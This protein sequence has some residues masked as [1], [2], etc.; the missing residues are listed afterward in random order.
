MRNLAI[1]FLFG[2][3][4]FAP[5]FAFAEDGPPPPASPVYPLN[6]ASS[7]SLPFELAWE[8]EPTANAYRYELIGYSDWFNQKTKEEQDAW[9]KEWANAGI[10]VQMEDGMQN[11][12]WM[13]MSQ[14]G[15]LEASVLKFLEPQHTPQQYREACK[16]QEETECGDSKLQQFITEEQ[17]HFW[18]VRSCKYSGEM[19]MEEI[20]C[21]PWGDTWSFTYLLA[22]PSLDSFSPAAGATSVKIY[23]PPITLKWGEVPGAK[24][25][26]ITASPPL[27]WLCEGLDCFLLSVL[28]PLEGVLKPEFQDDVCMFTKNTE[29]TWAA[30]SC[31]DTQAAFCGPLSPASSFTT[32]SS[33]SFPTKTQL[34]SPIYYPEDP[35]DPD[36]PDDSVKPE[37]IPLV[38]QQSKLF[39]SG[40]ACAYFY[41]IAITTED[42]DATTF[43]TNDLQSTSVR[44]DGQEEKKITELE[45]FWKDPKNLD[46]VFSWEA[47]PCWASPGALVEC[48]PS[49]SSEAWKFRTFGAAPTLQKPENGA[50]VKIP[51]ALQWQTMEGAPSYH[52]EIS[53]DAATK[54]DGSF[55][56]A[57]KKDTAMQANIQL[58]YEKDVMEPGKTYWWHVKTCVDTNGKV[59]GPWSEAFTFSTFTLEIPTTPNPLD[60]GIIQLDQSVSWKNVDAANAYAYRLEYACRDEKENKEE[61][62]AYGANVCPDTDAKRVIED[63]KV[64]ARNSFELPYCMGRYEW[65][66]LA[67]LQDKCQNPPET[68]TT[69]S[70]GGT[71]WKLI[72][73]QPSFAGAGLV[74]CGRLDNDDAT[75]FDETEKCQLKHLGFLLQNLLDFILWKLS[76]ATLLVLSVITGATSYFS[77]GGPNALAR[78]KTVFKSFFVG[79]LILV[80]AWAF[81][82][83]VLMLFGFQFELFGKWF[84][85]PF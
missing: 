63:N 60:E 34:S 79:F 4:A 53:T 81:V 36:D 29:Y 70:N 75:P 74:P 61:C 68:R 20:P 66:A 13:S 77:L 51:V 56:T 14:S 40:D 78:I 8:K 11:G 32:T 17:T 7:V 62:V 55:Q 39:W 48:N 50:T 85:I 52:Y 18:R 2:A 27:S 22:P 15:V 58:E 37:I 44:L 24:S 9:R 72:A 28:P 38:S 83:I 57:L 69:W 25:Y 45:Q 65:K 64:T 1:G 31:L 23:D 84:A 6:G 71:A 59:C 80:F 33:A 19:K 3:L 67:C 47:T 73:I 5:L 41:E 76:L 42:G 82:N 43:R 12:F 26:Q 16:A 54:P 21:G 46:K 10:T 30:A 35:D 49:D